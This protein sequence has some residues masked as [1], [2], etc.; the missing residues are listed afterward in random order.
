MKKFACLLLAVVTVGLLPIA[1]FALGVGDPAPELKAAQWVKHGPVDALDPAQTYVVEFWATWCGPCRSTIPH[2]TQMARQF[3]NVTF[4]GMNVW[5][6]GADPA[7]RVTEFVNSMGSKMDYA[8]AM[9]TTNWFMAKNWM[10]AAGQNG[11]PAAF[12]VHQGRI[13]WIGHPMGDLQETLQ[14][15]TAGTFNLETVRQRADA[16]QRVQN[17]V[18]KLMEGASDEEV[19]AEGAAIEALQADVGNLGPD[20]TPFVTAD[21]IQLVHKQKV[22]M[23]TRQKAMK[24]I[25]QYLAAIGPKGSAEEAAKMGAELEAL[26]LRNPGILNE[27][28]WHILTGEDVQHRDLPLATRLAKKAV[29][30]TAE[31]RGEILDTYARALFDAGQVAEALAWQQKAARV[32]PN[33]REIADTLQRYQAAAQSAAPAQE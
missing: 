25:E 26:D 9:D 27:I 16:E 31:R 24:T 21:M 1:A 18:V 13:A 10:E 7:P 2:L 30:L 12:V 3:T 11:I 14:A 5:E 33:D 23:E 29:E 20:G 4:I 15:I 8:V 17:F 28:A 6:R 22:E 32:A 19:A